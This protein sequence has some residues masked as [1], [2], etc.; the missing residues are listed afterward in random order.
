MKILLI[1]GLL[2]TAFAID[3]CEVDQASS[4][5][6]IQ[7]DETRLLNLNDYLKG[8]A[9]TFEADQPDITIYDS[10]VVSGS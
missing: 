4:R 5:I 9:L 10:Y 3:Y 2:V 1:I 6:F 8:S 7:P